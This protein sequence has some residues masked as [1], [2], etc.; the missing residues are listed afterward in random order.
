MM[1]QH[2]TGRNEELRRSYPPYRPS[3]HLEIIHVHYR[4]TIQSIEE[5]IGKARETKRFVVDTESQYKKLRK[6][7][8]KTNGAL[9]QI[10]IIHSMVYSTM[11]LIETDYLPDTKSILY[12]KIEE[13]CNI[14]FNNGNEIIT[15][16]P[17][18]QEFI[19]FHHLNL[20]HLGN[21]RKCDL[22][23][24]YS[25]PN[26][27]YDTHPEMER[28]ETTGDVSMKIDTTGDELIVF[29][30]DDD[31]NLED[32]DWDF[33]YDNRQVQRKEKL[34]PSLGLQ[35]AVAENFNKFLDKSYTKNDWN[36]GLDLNLNTW[37]RQR[38]SRNKYDE[39]EEK[40]QRQEML[41]Y[42]TH[43]C[44]SVAELYFKK[45]PEKMNDYLT[46]PETP[47]TTTTTIPHSE[48]AIIPV[49]PQSSTQNQSRTWTKRE[50]MLHQPELLNNIDE[51]EL[52]DF[53]RPALNQQRQQQQPL[54]TAAEERQRKKE[55]QR[56]KN[57]KYKE[58]KRSRPD[59][60]NRIIRPIY[61]RYDHRKIRAQLQEDQVHH[62]HEIHINQQ[63]GEVSINFKSEELKEEGK[64]KVPISYFSRTQYCERWGQ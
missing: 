51:H 22:Q 29:V 31:W 39:N 59:F 37:K 14:I 42:A 33:G 44:A 48:R 4:S 5:L 45:Y 34:N 25:N 32:D 62:S 28:R 15:W 55:I 56:R 1:N 54:R 36:C 58:K 13:L 53:L 57:E 60:N 18:E 64:K 6:G 43:D 35:T 47:I 46:P 49:E 52:I 38:F 23:F 26:Q 7:E 11:I 30:D 19:S 63:K 2:K 16:G 20:I 10:Q 21:Y 3:S 50:I 40:H 24:Y 9:I 27:K 61:H 17:I 12:K 41:Q 8:E